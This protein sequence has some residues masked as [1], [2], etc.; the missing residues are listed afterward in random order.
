MPSDLFL[1]CEACLIYKLPYMFLTRNYNYNNN[2]NNA[3]KV[4]VSQTGMGFCYAD[5]IYLNNLP[6]FFITSYR[7]LTA[8]FFLTTRDHGWRRIRSR[9]LFCTSPPPWGVRVDKLTKARSRPTRVHEPPAAL[10]FVI[11]V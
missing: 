1:T 2:N 3:N 8:Q 5:F 6:F 4:F 9:L 11:T 10:L 7:D